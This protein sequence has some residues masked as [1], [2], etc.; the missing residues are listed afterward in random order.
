ML[1][2]PPCALLLFA[3][4]A[5]SETVGYFDSDLCV[6]S[7]GFEDCYAEVDSWLS[8]CV[9]KNCAGGDD[10][11]T[12]ACGGD[13]TCMVKNCP[14]LGSDCV[15]A[16]ECVQHTKEIECVAQSCWN[17]VSHVVNTRCQEI[18]PDIDRAA[19][20]IPA[21]TS[22]L[23]VISSMSVST[24]ILSTFLFGRHPIMLPLVARA[25]WAKSTL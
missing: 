10:A 24:P 14:N 4:I 6:D 3:F 25:I 19:R 11:C 9:N 17:Q 12:K 22:R 7:A 2:R 13:V 1:L 8:T 18:M 5:R 15:S 23:L 21:S 16:C 20:S